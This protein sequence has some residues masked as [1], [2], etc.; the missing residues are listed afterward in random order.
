MK[1][2]KKKKVQWNSLRKTIK[3]ALIHKYKKV[4]SLFSNISLKIKKEIPPFEQLFLENTCYSIKYLYSINTF[5][6]Q[7]IPRN[8]K[9]T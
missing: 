2:K 5:K 8:Q 4:S 7:P 3:T 6:L 9:I 1:I